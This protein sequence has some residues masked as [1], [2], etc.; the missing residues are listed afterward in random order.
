MDFNSN[1]R[2]F[3]LGRNAGNGPGYFSADLRLGRKFRLGSDSPRSVEV[4]V[5]TF[6]LFNRVNFKG[7]NNNTG[8]LLFIDQLVGSE[9][10]LRGSSDLPA[11]SFRGF[12][13]AYDPRIVQLGLKLNF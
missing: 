4:I 3:G 5:D 8:G 10:R 9:L 7:V 11:T 1:D 12:T 6:N 13:S 2:P